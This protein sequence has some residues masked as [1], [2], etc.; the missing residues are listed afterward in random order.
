MDAQELLLTAARGVLV[1]IV[2]LVIIRLLGKRTVGN[3][4]PFDFL[5]ALMLGEVVDEIIYGDVNL[6]QGFT[7]VVVIA[8]LHFLNSWLGFTW[9]AFEKVTGGSPT[10]II[11]HG[12]LQRD[13][14]AKERM[15]EDEVWEELRMMAIDDLKAVKEAHV[16]TS[17]AVSVIREEWAKELQKGDLPGATSNGH[18]K[19][20]QTP[21]RERQGDR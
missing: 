13:G 6:V 2:F 21:A 14:M 8:L 1:Y 5:V 17:G 11:R 20:Q 9:P 16:E 19:S 15:S 10:L 3:F 4:T 12:E 18:K 7:A